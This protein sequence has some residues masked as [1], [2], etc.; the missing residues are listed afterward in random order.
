MRS[1]TRRTSVANRNAGNPALNTNSNGPNGKSAFFSEGMNLNYMRTFQSD[2]NSPKHISISYASSDHNLVYESVVLFY[3]LSAFLLQL[4]HLYRTV[5]WLP[6]S[7]E[8]N[9][10][11]SPLLQQHILLRAVYYLFSTLQKFYLVNPYVIGYVLTLITPRWLWTCCK[12]LITSILPNSLHK[13]TKHYCQ[14]VLLAALGGVHFYFL[15]LIAS[16]ES[17]EEKPNIKVNP[18]FR[19]GC[20]IYP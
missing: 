2:P 14:M 16:E 4:L 7:Y 6:Q 20:L 13:Q 1:A 5:W 17:N 15:F 11:V 9:A 12:T 18:I 8:N 10:V 3:S 19:L